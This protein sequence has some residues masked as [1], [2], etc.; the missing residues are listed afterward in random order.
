MDYLLKIYLVPIIIYQTLCLLVAIAGHN[1]QIGFLNAFLIS[2]FTTPII[3][4][5]V[6]VLT[7]P[8]DEL[9]MSYNKSQ[10]INENNI[11][12]EIEKLYELKEKGIINDS[13]FE[14][15]KKKLLD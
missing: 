6:T 12:T 13:E 8:I 11:S 7:K 9:Q 3:G 14:N 15:S 5:I 1:R 4:L 2:F 10:K